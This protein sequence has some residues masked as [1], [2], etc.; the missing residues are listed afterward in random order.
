MVP[1]VGWL[2]EINGREGLSLDPGKE[3]GIS[4]WLNYEWVCYS[5]VDRQP[6]SEVL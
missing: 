1:S 4:S 5:G 6:Y 3:S 2:G